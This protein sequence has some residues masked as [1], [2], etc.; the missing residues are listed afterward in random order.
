MS[1]TVVKEIPKGH[2][3]GLKSLFLTSKSGITTDTTR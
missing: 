2:P 1:Q 3:S